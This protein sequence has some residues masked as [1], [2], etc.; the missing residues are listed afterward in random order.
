LEALIG[1]KKTAQIARENNVHPL[2]VG[3]MESDY[4]GADAGV[5]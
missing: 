1:V 3:A 5:V 4:S 2:L